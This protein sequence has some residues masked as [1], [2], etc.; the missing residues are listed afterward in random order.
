VFY[1]ASS[2]QSSLWTLVFIG[3]LVIVRVLHSR[4]THPINPA[5]LVITTLIGRNLSLLLRSG[6]LPDGVRALGKR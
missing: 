2:G 5:L 1:G 4:G 3:V 6:Q